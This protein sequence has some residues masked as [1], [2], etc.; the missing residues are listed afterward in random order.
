MK[1]LSHSIILVAVITAMVYA[2]PGLTPQARAVVYRIEQPGLYEGTAVIYTEGKHDFLVT[3]YHMVKDDSG[4]VC[5]S[6][7]LY[8]N[9]IADN[10]EV[11]SGPDHVTV[12]LI[13]KTDTVY[14]QSEIEGVDIVMVSLGGENITSSVTDKKFSKLSAKVIP[15]KE[16]LDKVIDDKS[17]LTAVGYPGKRT[18]PASIARYP[19]YRWGRIVGKDKMFIRTNLPVV[20]GSSGSP[21]FIEYNGGYVLVGIVTG[22]KGDNSVLLRASDIKGCFRKC[23]EYMSKH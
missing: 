14:F 4:K 23:F 20:H 2:Q 22:L 21:V 9:H 8:M 1:V 18:V 11:I 7:F 19:E 17:I 10:G 5:D 12:H 15:T 3:N 16:E 6:L 13:I